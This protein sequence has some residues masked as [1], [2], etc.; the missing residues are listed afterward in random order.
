VPLLVR[1]L[2][3]LV[4]TGYSPEH[5]VSGIT[6]PFL[7]VKV[8]RLMRI[9]GRGDAGA[10]DAMNDILAQVAT[11]TDASKNVGNAV[12]YESVLA[13]LEIEADA[14]LRVLA[15]NILGKFLTNRDNNIRYVALTTLAKVVALDTPAVQRHRNT[16]LDCLRDGDI[17]IRRR[18]LELAYALVD[19]QNVRVMVRE[20]LAFLELADDEF[21]R[22]LTT[23]LA[24]AA[25]RF[26]PN[27]R[28]HIDTVL[29]VL[30]LV[31]APA[32]RAARPLT[33]PPA[34]GQLRARGDPVRVHPPRRAHARAA[35][36]HGLA[37]VRGAARG[38]L[39]GVAH[40]RGDLGARR[41]R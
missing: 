14:G 27:K 9:L 5:D 34:G 30:K 32:R 21:K 2:K 28:W 18:A 1:A 4:T 40:A 11:N 35:G 24:L 10:S 41:V 8:L 12:L 37:A 6:D 29:R 13:I 17:S 26:A 7:Q 33:R 36:V 39:A 38:P 22:G 3:S 19:A 16:I 25:E 20:L 15:I 23:Q 31:R